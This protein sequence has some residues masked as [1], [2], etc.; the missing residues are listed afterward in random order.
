MSEPVSLEDFN[1]NY[2]VRVADFKVSES[3]PTVTTVI[4]EIKNN[5]NL[6]VGVFISD[7]DSTTLAS[8]YTHNDVLD[9]AWNDV[10]TSANEWATVNL[11][12][13]GYSTYTVLS[14][15]DDITLEDFN[16][17]YTVRVSRFELYPNVSPTSWC[18][19]FN[20]SSNTKPGVN[21]YVDSTIGLADYCN[22][23]LCKTVAGAVWDL[24]KDR[25]CIWAAK[26]LSSP[27]VL[28][29]QYVPSSVAV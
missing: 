8:E 20:V 26:E 9:A 2:T 13:P 29:S 11:P 4:F 5:V 27:P 17:N 28:N 14:T 15:T 1:T 21:L 24:V 12:K 23:V 19:G 25:V 22:N 18:I 16:T 3:V 6:R 7:V 10:K